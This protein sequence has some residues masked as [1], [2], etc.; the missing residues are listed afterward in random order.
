MILFSHQLPV[1]CEDFMPQDPAQL[2]SNVTYL[3][4]VGAT[5][6]D[7]MLGITNDEGATFVIFDEIFQNSSEV[8]I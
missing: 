4:D 8:G 3:D 7:V 1:V 2:I 6:R 5:K